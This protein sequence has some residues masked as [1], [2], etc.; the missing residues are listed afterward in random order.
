MAQATIDLFAEGSE[1]NRKCPRRRGNVVYLP[2]QGSL[3]VAGDLHGPHVSRKKEPQGSF[4]QL[5][6]FFLWWYNHERR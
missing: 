1:V 4:F 6:C 3:V 2:D 5:N